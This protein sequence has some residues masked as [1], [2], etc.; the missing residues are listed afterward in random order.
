MRIRELLGWKV[1]RYGCPECV[2]PLLMKIEDGVVVVWCG[3]GPCRSKAAN[4]GA[5]AENE[6]MA[7]RALAASVMVEAVNAVITGT[8]AA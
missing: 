2:E 7:V 5:K 8:E 4:E 6:E 3:Y 1:S